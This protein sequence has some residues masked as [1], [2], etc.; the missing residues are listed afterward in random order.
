MKTTAF[1]LVFTA[2]LA[3]AQGPLTPPGPPAPTMKSLDQ[4]EARTPIPASPATPIAGPH[5]TITESGS[6]YLTGNITVA[7]GDAIRIAGANAKSVTLDLNG[8]TITSALTGGISGSGIVV[9]TTLIRLTIRNGN[10][11]SGTT[12]TVASAAKAGFVSGISATSLYCDTLISDIHVSGMGESGIVCGGNSVVDRCTVTRSGGGSGIS[13][14]RVRDC[15]VREIFSVGINASIVTGSSAFSFNG[16]GINADLAVSESDGK[17][18]SGGGI[19][20]RGNVTLSNGASSSG[21]GLSAKNASI[22]TGTSNSGI[23]LT[24]ENAT[25]CTGTTTAGSYGLAASKNASDCTGT[26]TSP[27]G[28]GEGLGVDGNA[29]NCTGT[30]TAGTGLSARN[31]TGCRGTTVTGP[32]GLSVWENAS[33]STGIATGGNGRGFY[34]GENATNCMGVSTGGIGLGAI[35]ATTC[36]GTTVTGTYGLQALKNASDSSGTATG[37]VGQGLN[38]GANASNSTGHSEGGPGLVTNMADNCEGTT[39]NGFYGVD[40]RV[41][42]NTSGFAQKDGSRGLVADIAEN[43]YGSNNIGLGMMVRRSATNCVGI[44]THVGLYVTG[45]ASYCTGSGVWY[46]ISAN[47]AIGC[48]VMVVG[49]RILSDSKHLGTP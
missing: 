40:A 27:T 44:G 24:A 9:S 32:W 22:S 30:S 17:S 48:G 31:A 15:I 35:N 46:A 23:G 11:S 4:I 33:D 41:A 26:V 12:V 3:D 7:T 49:E 43:C 38:A 37:G 29:T 21:I 28:T 45:I 34:A 42:A 47:V 19:V 5:F 14:M 39:V 1:L 25:T 13:A 16:T 20:C 6:Y 36:T 10:I 2:A 8:F 18:I